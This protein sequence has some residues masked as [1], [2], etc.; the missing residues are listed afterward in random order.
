VHTRHH[1]VT[2]AH[3][4]VPVIVQFSLTAVPGALQW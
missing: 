4:N 1:E 2:K 3:V